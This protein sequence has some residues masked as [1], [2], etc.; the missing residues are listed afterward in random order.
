MLTRLLR[1]IEVV[2]R[3]MAPLLLL[4]LLR[5]ITFDRAAKSSSSGMP[6]AVRCMLE[7]LGGVFIKYGQLLAMRPD[8]VSREYIAELSL[9]LDAVPPFS[10]DEAAL[11]VEQ[12]FG[13]PLNNALRSFQR[14]QIAAASF[15][16]VHEAVL[17]SGERVVIKILRPGLQQIVRADIALVMVIARLIDFLGLM[18]RVK[19]T[20]LAQDFED[21]TEEELDLRVEATYAQ[22][23]RDVSA[24]DPHS[25]IPR[26]YWNYTTRRVMTMEYMEGFWVSEALNLIDTEG[27]E[28]ARQILISRDIDLDEVASNI[29]DNQLRQVFE[30]RLFHADPHA[31]NLVIMDANIIGYVDF[32]ITGELDSEFR[33]TQLMLYDALQRRDSGQYMRAIYRIMKPP[34]DNVDLDAFEREIK[35]NAAA[36]QNSLHNPTATLQERSSSWLFARN[37][38]VTR[39]YGL[40]VSQVALR[41]YRALSVVELIVLRLNPKFDFV[42][43]LATYLRQLQLRELAREV[44]LDERFTELLASRRLIYDS[45]T[46]LRRMLF[47]RGWN[48]GIARR[49]V[50]RWQVALAGLLKLGAL[51]AVAGCVVVPVA[52]I[53]HSP[54]ALFLWQFG[55][56]R[57]VLGL[58]AVAMLF[59][60]CAQRLYISSTCYGAVLVRAKS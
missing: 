58:L 56:G 8:V 3:Y 52:A 16:Q 4:A 22:R 46:E 19:L 43:A 17:P 15:A 27:L 49:H 13:V 9:L 54:T 14:R 51:L 55:V 21:W 47:V 34:P 28:G 57:T 6:R 26:I 25:R 10:G 36:W 45:V 2:A 59:A 37:L 23:L 53:W 48:E 1:I 31:G 12:E 5:L 40:E 24:N 7:D 33:S 38:K 35:R 29:I 42:T 30:H 50:S 41:Y 32:G 60:W 20:P 44:R 11:I 18:K 39:E